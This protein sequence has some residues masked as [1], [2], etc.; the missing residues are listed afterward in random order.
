MG[1]APPQFHGSGPRKGVEDRPFSYAEGRDRS[2][3]DVCVRYL[4]A[5][6][7]SLYRWTGGGGSPSLLRAVVVSPRASWT[8]GG[9]RNLLCTRRSP[10][11]TTAARALTPKAPGQRD[12]LPGRTVA[13]G[14]RRLQHAGQ[15]V[16]ARL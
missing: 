9:G 7:P 6:D 4:R 5:S 13:V 11:L 12:L 14:P 8:G 16:E 2:H 10:G 3:A 1:Q 15:P